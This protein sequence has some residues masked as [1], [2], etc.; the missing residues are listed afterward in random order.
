MTIAYLDLFTGLSGDMFLGAL[1]DAGCPLQVMQVAL[2]DLPLTLS[3]E[4]VTRGGL[5]GTLVSVT[6]PQEQPHHRSYA[7]LAALLSG[8]G[9][10]PPLRERAEG[11]LHRLAE[12]EAAVHGVPVEEVHFHEL[13]GLDTLADLVGAGTRFEAAMG[14]RGGL[15][16]AALASRARKAPGFALLGENQSPRVA[17]EKRGVE[18]FLKRADLAADRRL[19]QVQLVARMGQRPRVGH[20]MKYSELVP[21]HRLPTSRVNRHIHSVCFKRPRRTHAP[22]S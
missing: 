21:V 1:V 7:E 20:R 13:G 6:G 16:N 5:R 2:G 4:T 19:A 3:A 22:R 11:I 12:A 8:L 9:L 17:M 14:G 15:G 18:A 10:S